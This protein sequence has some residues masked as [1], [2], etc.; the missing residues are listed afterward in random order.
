[1]KKA[2][3]EHKCETLPKQGVQLLLYRGYRLRDPLT[4]VLV[5]RREASE[6]DLWKNTILEEVGQTLFEAVIEISH[7]PYCGE[8]LA[9]GEQCGFDDFGRFTLTD[10]TGWHSRKI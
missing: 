6:E 4:W 9:T 5:I 2:W 3:E 1:M 10:R 8:E 7:C